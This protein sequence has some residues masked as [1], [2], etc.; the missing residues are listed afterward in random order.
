[1]RTFLDKCQN[2]ER[3]RV[4]AM[5]CELTERT[6]FDSAVQTVNQAILYNATDPESLKTLYRRLYSD[7]PKL[8]PLEMTATMPKV[9]QFPADLETYDNLLRKKVMA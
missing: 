8:A 4:L 6:G 3:G 2:T 1:M 9:V 5:L 7:I